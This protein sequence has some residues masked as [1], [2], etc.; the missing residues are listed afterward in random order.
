[1]PKRH[2]KFKGRIQRK[3]W[4]MGPFAGVDYNLTLCPLQRRLLHIY[5]GQ[6]MPESTL[7]L[8][9]SCLHPPSQG[10]WI[11]PMNPSC[12]PS[13]SQ[14]VTWLSNTVLFLLKNLQYA[15]LHSYRWTI[16]LTIQH[17]LHSYRV[18][19]NIF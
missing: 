16:P 19:G 4:C 12:C 6:P 15:Y 9:Q 1:M 7:T 14:N 2:V 13:K 8:C 18:T 5:H 17:I 11:W 3:T 10:L